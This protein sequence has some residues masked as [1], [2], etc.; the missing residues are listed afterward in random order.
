MWNRMPMMQREKRLRVD[1]KEVDES[2]GGVRLCRERGGG[3]SSAAAHAFHADWDEVR[4]L[5]G[6]VMAPK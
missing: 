5:K 2:D 1:A 6:S 3:W 4:T